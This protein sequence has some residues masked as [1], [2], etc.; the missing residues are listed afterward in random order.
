[1]GMGQV[2]SPRVSS[3]I[4]HCFAPSMQCSLLMNADLTIEKVLQQIMDQARTLLGATAASVFLTDS[5]RLYLRSTINSTGRTLRIPIVKG[6]AGHVATTGEPLIVPDAYKDARFDQS[7][8]KKTGFKT[9]TILCV[10]LKDR[11]G[12]ILGVVQLIN[13]SGGG[14]FTDQ[15][16]HFLQVFACQASTAI[17]GSGSFPDRLDL[18]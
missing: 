8:D 14:S 9:D 13:K 11:K 1:M 7:V 6:I 4:L 17:T 10:P 5:D 15:D 3:P 2:W 16:L 12:E 18:D